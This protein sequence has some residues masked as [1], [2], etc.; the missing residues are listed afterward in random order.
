MQFSKFLLILLTS[1]S[2]VFQLPAQKKETLLTKKYPPQQLREDAL[3]FRDVI[4]AM[5]PSLGLYQS[6][7]YYEKL[8]NNFV[9][10]L[11]DSLT[12]KGF[13]LKLKLIADELHCGHTEVL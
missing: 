1:C 2:L 10:S 11:N 3:I 13:R 5:H 7:V 6:R 8:L 4:L 12:E 9:L